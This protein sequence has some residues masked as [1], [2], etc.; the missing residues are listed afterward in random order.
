MNSLFRRSAAALGLLAALAA[1]GDTEV[2]KDPSSGGGPTAE[3]PATV[4]SGMTLDSLYTVIGTGTFTGTGP[5]D[6]I[7][8]MHGHRARMIVTN[9]RIFRVLFVRKGSGTLDGPIE[10]S[11]D[12]PIV[13]ENQRV[14]ANGWAEFDRLAK[15]LNLPALETKP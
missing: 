9:N 10:R 3:A 12:T 14:L 8:V 13:L 5:A 11:Q 15:E 2:I 7:R 6:T 1:C 4:H